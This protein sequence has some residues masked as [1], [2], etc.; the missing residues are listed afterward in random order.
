MIPLFLAIASASL[1]VPLTPQLARPASESVSLAVSRRGQASTSSDTDTSRKDETFRNEQKVKSNE[2]QVINCIFLGIVAVS[3]ALHFTAVYNP[4]SERMGRVVLSSSSF[5]QCCGTIA[6]A[7]TVI[8]GISH[9]SGICF[10]DCKSTGPSGANALSVDDATSLTMS[11]CTLARS[12]GYGAHTS[13]IRTAE[14]VTVATTNYSWNAAGKNA[15]VCSGFSVICRNPDATFSV[16][17][18]H[19][20]NCSNGSLLSIDRLCGCTLANCVF[21]EN[22]ARSL[23]LSG[24][25]TFEGCYFIEQEL[26]PNESTPRVVFRSCFFSSA[27]P[28]LFPGCIVTLAKLNHR[29]LPSISFLNTRYCPSQIDMAQSKSHAFVIVLAVL[30]ALLGIVSATYYIGESKLRYDVREALKYVMY[31]MYAVVGLMFVIRLGFTGLVILVIIVALACI[32]YQYRGALGDEYAGRIG[33]FVEN[34]RAAWHTWTSRDNLRV[35]AEGGEEEEQRVIVGP[36][37]PPADTH[38]VGPVQLP[39]DTHVAEFSDG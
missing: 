32:V 17:L 39:A 8:R 9:L 27:T 23:V 5:S 10:A 37:Q 38:V 22:S 2:L 13:H 7:L 11:E 1:G 25:L 20:E 16:E 14:E 18:L 31:G 6:G 29:E 24:E 15:S 21:T 36:V 12:I 3:S 30:I 26:A 34:A 19:V 33:G 28:P 35:E 4:A